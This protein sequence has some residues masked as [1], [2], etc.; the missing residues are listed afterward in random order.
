MGNWTD[1]NEIFA[2][3]QE[4]EMVK[5]INP[6][7]IEIGKIKAGIKGEEVTSASGATFRLPQKLDH[8]LVCTNEKDDQGNY[9]QDKELMDRL[10]AGKEKLVEIPIRLLSDDIDWNFP[11]RYAS[12]VK[13]RCACS[14]DGETAK[15]LGVDTPIKCPCQKLQSGD[16]KINGTLFCVIDGIEIFGGVHVFRTTSMNT[17]KSILGS[18]QAIKIVTGGHLSFLPLNLIIHPKSTVIPSTGQ[19][20]KIFVVSVI[21]KGSVEKLRKHALE[22]AK[23]EHQYLIELKGIEPFTDAD[24]DEFYPEVPA[25]TITEAMPAAV[26]HETTVITHDITPYVSLK[27]DEFWKLKQAGFIDFTEKNYSRFEVTP[28][29]IMFSLFQ[30]WEKIMG[31]KPFP[32]PEL[33]SYIRYQESK[34]KGEI[35]EEEW[36][37]ETESK[38]AEVTPEPTAAPE[39]PEPFGGKKEQIINLFKQIVANDSEYALKFLT[40]EGIDIPIAEIQAIVKSKD[41]AKPEIW[42][43]IIGRYKPDYDSQSVITAIGYSCLT[44]RKEWDRGLETIGITSFAAQP[45]TPSAAEQFLRAVTDVPF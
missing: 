35:K 21:Y 25:A 23:T 33:S 4:I 38:S 31:I 1:N 24:A 40:A 29:D 14:G 19:P 34:K 37:E 3:K 36:E 42:A 22:M 39:T 9:L 20:T 2:L 11:T 44:G 32:Y 45:I 30:K 8:F 12:Y 17:C 28:D 6:S 43:G 5:G 10:L 7:L 27:K 15:M 18:L 26:T 41:Y 16:C 13:G